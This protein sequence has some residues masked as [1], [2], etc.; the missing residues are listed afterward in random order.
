M[1]QSSRQNTPSCT[2]TMHAKW[3][4]ETLISA[5]Y[6]AWCHIPEHQ[7]T[8][9]GMRILNLYKQ[10]FVMESMIHQATA[11][12]VTAIAELTYFPSQKIQQ[13]IQH[14]LQSA[15]A[16]EV[17]SIILTS[18]IN[19]LTDFWGNFSRKNVL[20]EAGNMVHM[21]HSTGLWTLQMTLFSSCRNTSNTPLQSSYYWQLFTSYFS[22]FHSDHQMLVHWC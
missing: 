16:V 8:F 12:W 19:M 22:T 15:R 5:Y 17:L 20:Y 21:V 7:T 1:P 4:S 9:I 2:L 3:A 18:G 11:M 10:M 13:V 14:T 6:T